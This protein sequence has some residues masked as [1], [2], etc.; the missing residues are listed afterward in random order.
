MSYENFTYVYVPQDF[1]RGLYAVF[2][3]DLPTMYT[4]PELSN[5]SEGDSIPE[6]IDSATISFAGGFLLVFLAFIVSNPRTTAKFPDDGNGVSLDV[7]T[8]AVGDQDWT[9][10]ETILIRFNDTQPGRFPVYFEYGPQRTEV[11]CDAAVCV[12]KYEPWIIEAYNTSFAP[13]SILRIVEQGNN[14][15]SPLPPSGSIRGDPIASTRYLNTTEKTTEFWKAHVNV[16]EQMRRV[17]DGGCCYV[18]TP[19]VRPVIPRG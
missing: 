2:D 5:V 7:G 6:D 16:M 9:T 8:P 11:G 12:H 13:P 14:K 18:P 1:I 17:N 4:I 10:V 19:N 15:T 3:M